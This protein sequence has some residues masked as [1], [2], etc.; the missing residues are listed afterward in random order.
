MTSG[1]L[2]AQADLV[3]VGKNHLPAS[4]SAV[5]RR[6]DFGYALDGR[7]GVRIERSLQV[8]W[9]PCRNPPTH[10]MRYLGTINVRPETFEAVLIDICRSVKRHGFREI[11]FL[12]D[13]GNNQEGRAVVAHQLDT[14]WRASDDRVRVR[15]IKEYY[16]R[17]NRGRDLLAT[18]DLP[19][20]DP[21]PRLVGKTVYRAYRYESV[22]AIL[23]PELI[24]AD[25]RRA[26]GLFQVKWLSAGSYR[27]DDCQWP[28]PRGA[29]GEDYGG[30]DEGRKADL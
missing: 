27:E 26:E 17:D 3:W 10:H 4:E 23:D 22:M 1:R 12:G 14:D 11:L 6:Q 25:A 13:S 9:S 20:A 29:P 2:L 18:F 7:I 5:D 19:P 8:A 30:C 16:R 28:A 15:F 21:D 24:R